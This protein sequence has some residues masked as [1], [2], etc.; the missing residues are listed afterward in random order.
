MTRY[1]K[2]FEIAQK[3]EIRFRNLMN[4]SAIGAL[5]GLLDLAVGLIFVLSSKESSSLAKAIDSTKLGFLIAGIL[6]A[7]SF[8]GYL[9]QRNIAVLGQSAAKDIVIR[10]NTV[11]LQIPIKNLLTRD[12]A[13]LLNASTNWAN[14]IGG[15]LISPLI[16]IVSDLI[17]LALLVVLLTLILGV[18]VL[19]IFVISSFLCYLIYKVTASRIAEAANI[20]VTAGVKLHSLINSSL[21]GAR[22]VRQFN[23]QQSI[24]NEINQLAENQAEA[25]SKKIYLAAIPRLVIEFMGSLIIFLIT[26]NTVSTSF[27][28]YSFIKSYLFSF[29]NKWCILS[30]DISSLFGVGIPIDVHI[31]SKLDNAPN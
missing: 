3:F 10:L 30:P 11:F 27:S 4:V 23:L 2:Y 22:E 15:N 18:K 25:Q 31:S 12:F 14:L 7:R 1:K 13:Y 20:G 28:Q 16:A 5:V 8:L 29:Q 21:L 24:A 17:L 26:S 19:V 9:M 6:V